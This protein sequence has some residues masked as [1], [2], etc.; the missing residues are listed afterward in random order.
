M[1]IRNFVSDNVGRA[2]RVLLR[3]R[4]CVGLRNLMVVA[5]HKS[6]THLIMNIL[7]QVGL[8]GKSIG[9]GFMPG[10]FLA[11]GP[12]EY[13]LSHYTPGQPVYDLIERGVVQA[14]FHYRDPRDI[15]V[16]RFHWQNPKNQKVTNVT[17]EFLKTVHSRF[18]SD[19]EFLEFIIRGQK[20][21]RHEIVLEEQFRLS[22][23]LLFHPNVYKTRFEDIIG[24]KG[25]GSREK[26][27]EVIRDLLRYL[28][29]D[30]SPELVASKAFSEDVET[31]HKGKIGQ[32]KHYFD[33]EISNLFQELHGDILRD[34]GYE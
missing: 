1:S 27:V 21:I 18:K 12:N 13:L 20:H 29:I 23:G 16:S 31:F 26:Q 22:R 14:V 28:G 9:E 5:L 15:C 3:L 34:Y 7:S 30:K 19:K 33:D 11:L 32:Y 24:P 17:R 6:G 8:K 25:G 10:H 2:Q 4:K